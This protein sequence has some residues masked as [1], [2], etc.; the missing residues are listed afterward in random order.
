MESTRQNG[1]QTEQAPGQHQ[2][3][4]LGRAYAYF[5]DSETT[6]HMF[7]AGTL[8][9]SAKPTEVI[10]IDAI[11]PGDLMTRDFDLQNNGSL[12]IKKVSLKTSGSIFKLN[13]STMRI[14]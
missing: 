5:S 3:R 2:P 6:N 7:A 12:D 14:S 4:E 1:V 10:N 13:F 9:L 8:D 11:K